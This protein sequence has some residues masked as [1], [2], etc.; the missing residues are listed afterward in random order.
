MP[1][2][3][4]STLLE[5]TYYTLFLCFF[6]ATI[7]HVDGTP[8]LSLYTV[9]AAPQPFNTCCPDNIDI[10]PVPL[11]NTIYRKL[12]PQGMDSADDAV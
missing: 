9:Y 8:I 4:S 6:P 5:P 3:T 1:V 7:V 10:D 11:R 2:L 12:P